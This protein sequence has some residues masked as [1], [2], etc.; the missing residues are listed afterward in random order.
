MFYPKRPEIL[1]LFCVPH[2]TPTLQVEPWNQFPFCLEDI[3]F[4]SEEW[5]LLLLLPPPT[6]G[7]GA[8]ALNTWFWKSIKLNRGQ[9]GKEKSLTQHGV[10]ESWCHG[11]IAG[12]MPPQ[13]LYKCP[14]LS[15]PCGRRT[16]LLLLPLREALFLRNR[17]ILTLEFSYR[18]SRYGTEGEECCFF[19]SSVILTSQLSLSGSAAPE[20]GGRISSGEA[21]LHSSSWMH[22]F[23]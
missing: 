23:I 9:G 20:G 12:Q 19:K 13:E 6:F 14:A 16:L 22:L 11:G 8:L 3:L 15:P 10:T 5:E 4:H 2:L 18:V 7:T 21:A 17:F 1:T